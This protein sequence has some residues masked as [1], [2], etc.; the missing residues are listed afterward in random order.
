[1]SRDPIL[2]VGPLPP[3]LNGMT[4]MTALARLGLSREGVP[5]AF[6]DLSD[7]RPVGNV[8]RLDARNV[9]LAFRHS[10]RMLG[11]LARTRPRLVYLPIAQSTLG[12]LRDALLILAARCHRVPVVVHLH[13][14]SFGTFYRG[15]N[16]LVRAVVRWCLSEVP[17]AIVLSDRSRSAFEGLVP[18]DRIRVLPNGI[19][20]PPGFLPSPDGEDRCD[21]LYMS[22]LIEGKGY[23]DL[24]RA[25][26]AVARERPDVR[27]R[28][29][30][31]WSS[32]R[33][34]REVL[35]EVRR[36]GIA[37]HVRFVSSATGL[38]KAQLFR[39]ARVFVFP[40]TAV[41]GQPVVILEAM[42]HGLPVVSTPLGGIRETVLENET[43]LLVPPGR[44][45]ILA[46]AILRLLQDEPLRAR[47]GEAGR[48]RFHREHG[49]VSFQRGLK[50]LLEPEAC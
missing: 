36:L 26:P 7:H 47:L 5:L 38:R 1:M 8:G 31:E 40:P 14:S 43:G 41:E 16:G 48:R 10:F 34:R 32:D 49:F 37:E 2:L 11:A 6:L 24:V 21:V 18:A 42:S 9:L 35:A 27:V 45:E 15:A 33:E 50:S 23:R 44:P 29:A 22:N 25:I 46:K 17:L 4:V 30:G 3:P 28:L 20:A 12:F 39:G 13:G 19:P